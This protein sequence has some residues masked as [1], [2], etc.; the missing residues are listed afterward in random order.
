MS[1]SEPL[2]SATKQRTYGVLLSQYCSFS[3]YRYCSMLLCF[4]SSLYCYAPLYIVMLF[5]ILLYSSLYCYTPLYIVMLLFILLC[6]SLYCY[7]PLYLVML[8]FI[9]I[10]SSLYCYAPLFGKKICILAVCV[11]SSELSLRYQMFYNVSRGRSQKTTSS[12]VKTVIY[13]CQIELVLLLLG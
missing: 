9:L 5:F 12:I 8:L 2:R 4:C 7:A 3:F 6:S 1:H 13:I 10:C 11:F